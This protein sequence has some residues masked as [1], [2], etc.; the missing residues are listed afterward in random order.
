MHERDI[1]HLKAYVLYKESKLPSTWISIRPEYSINVTLFF[2]ILMK[3]EAQLHQHIFILLI[4]NHLLLFFLS[5]LLLSLSSFYILCKSSQTFWDLLPLLLQFCWP[6]NRLLM[7]TQWPRAEPTCCI[8]MWPP[9]IITESPTLYKHS[10][11]S[12]SS[13]V[14]MNLYIILCITLNCSQLQQSKK[15]NWDKFIL[16]MR[17]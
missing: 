16:Q 14:F 17:L 8:Q 12:L 10:F 5:S 3:H 11:N 1:K 2:S 15:K 7:A 6:W 13:H 4:T 9:A